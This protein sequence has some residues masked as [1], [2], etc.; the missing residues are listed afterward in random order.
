M[1]RRA[2]RRAKDRGAAMSMRKSWAAGA[3]ALA[4]AACMTPQ[5]GEQTDV[6]APSPLPIPY[7]TTDWAFNG[8]DYFN[9]R[10]S[11]LTEI[12]RDNVA[13]LKGV[14][15]ARL[16]GS[17]ASP[18]NSGEA[19][20]LVVDGVVY[21]ITGDDDVF[22]I[23]VETGER[24]WKYT[25]NLDQS[26]S[27]ICCGWLSRGVGYGE[28]RVFVGQLDGQL[29][30]LDAATGEVAWSVQAER[31]QDGFSITSAPLYY[32]GMVITGFAGAEYTARGRVKAYD[33]A[34]GREIWTFYTVP[35]PGEPGSETWPADSNVWRYGGATVWQTPAVDPELGLI[36]FSTGNPAPDFNGAVRE[37]DNL[38]T[39]SV[40]ALDAA[41]GEYRWHFQAVRHDIWDYDLPTPVI[42]FDAPIDGTMRKGIAAT[43]KTGWLYIL[44]RETGEPL[45]G[46]EDRPVPQEPAQRTAASQPYPI[47]DAYIPQRV[48]IAPEGYELVNEG[49][50]FTPFLGAAGVP[51]NPSLQGGANWP[52]SSYDPTTNLYYVCSSNDVGVFRGGDR[53]FEE[54]EA[55]VQYIGGQVGLAPLPA[56]GVFA[57][58]DV[59]TN[60]IVWRHAWGEMCYSGSVTTA[61]GLVFV[62]RND[63]R[64]TALDSS[65]GRRLWEFQTG[66]GMNAPASVFEHGGK[67]YVVAY[68]AGNLFARSAKGDSVWLFALDGTL[69]PVAPGTPVARLAPAAAA[70]THEAVLAAEPDLEAGG[71]VYATS[72]SF[73]HGPA[74]HGGNSGAPLPGGLTTQTIEAKLITGGPQMP[75]FEAVLSPAER[76]DV[77]AYVAEVLLENR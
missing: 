39:A 44:D 21:I 22:A 66:A 77:A 41:T 36:Y 38:F 57:A 5:A 4:A 63:G 74:G 11:P 48:D 43:G 34:T 18:R 7:P 16:D 33:A 26:I 51:V 40:M 13:N 42:L 52:P 31:W 14:W 17:G 47:G 37:G 25:A 65:T 46:I 54:P 32:D 20:P 71:Q 70:P 68:S 50:I 45:I 35:A 49:R 72:C 10:Y 64:L 53:D 59:T 30:A 19:Q 12:N 62:G 29:K 60:R 8:G 61:G 55:G 67:Q 56:T 23:D 58:F 15:Q 73:C 3:L 1:E 69:D 28:G 2:R 6:T 75:P 27:T 76:R 24:L 9:R